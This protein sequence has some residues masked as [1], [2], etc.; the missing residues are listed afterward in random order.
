MRLARPH[1][2]QVLLAAIAIVP[3]GAP[4]AAAPAAAAENPETEAELSRAAL[5]LHGGAQFADSDPAGM[6]QLPADSFAEWRPRRGLNSAA[7][8]IMLSLMPFWDGV[9]ANNAHTIASFEWSGEHGH[10]ALSEGSSGPPSQRSLYL[11]FD[12]GQGIA[13]NVRW[14]F[15]YQFFIRNQWTMVSVVWQ[16]GDPGFVR[17]FVDA[18]RICEGKTKFEGGRVSLNPV[19]LG[20]D[21]AAAETGRGGPGAMALRALRIDDRPL[22]DDEIRRAY[23]QHGGDTRP[24]WIMAMTSEKSLR[25]PA[26]E[27]RIMLDEDTHWSSSK[28]E[29][30]RRLARIKGAG[31]NIYMPNVWD[32]ANAFFSTDKAPVHPIARDP[33]DPRYD[34]LN[35]LIARAHLLGIQVHTWVYVA[36][37]TAPGFPDEFVAGAPDGAFNV[38]SARFRDYIVALVLDLVARHDV[39]GVNLDYIRAIGPCSSKECAL[40]YRNRYGRSLLDDWDSAARG[41]SIPSLVQWNQEAITDIVRRIAT[42]MRKLRPKA[43]LTVDSVMFDYLRRQQGL[44]EEGWLRKGILDAVVNMSYDDPIDIDGLDRALRITTPAHLVVAV[45][46]FDL[47]DNDVFDRPG[48]AMA[49]YVQLIRERWPGAGI[50]FYHYPHLDSDQMMELGHGVFATASVPVWTR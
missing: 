37:R 42:G 2:L 10:F 18:K 41:I 8:T 9:Q 21:R 40:A 25:A 5:T 31:L 11:L 34:P 17:L 33:A 19:Y 32:G 30:E 14:N 50:A 26:A 13:C 35:Y 22:S 47:F 1:V 29:M 7:G 16:S 46:N 23:L 24:K 6:L 48:A 4:A 49:D 43:V 12:S 3:A 28:L 36:R 20:S 27:R 15:Y 44:D 39:D 45:R 38:H